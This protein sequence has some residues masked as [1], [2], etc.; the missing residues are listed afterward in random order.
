M[1]KRTSKRVAEMAGRVLALTDFRISEV[2]AIAA[3]VLAQA[4]PIGPLPGK[5]SSRRMA[6]LAARVADGGDFS[7]R[8]AMQ[9]AGSAVA[10]Y[11]RERPEE[12]ARARCS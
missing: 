8:E 11:E 4:E 2:R 5:R 12:V 10:Q 3:S 7:L 9:L 1:A 6:A